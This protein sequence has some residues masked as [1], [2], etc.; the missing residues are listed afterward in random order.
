MSQP[1]REINGI[2]YYASDDIESAMTNLFESRCSINNNFGQDEQDQYYYDPSIE[3]EIEECS[4]CILN[5]ADFIYEIESM[6]CPSEDDLAKLQI[7]REQMV[8]Y[9]EKRRHLFDLLD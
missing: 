9:T 7:F 3:F 2:D 5:L 4:D 1:P 6:K 8:F